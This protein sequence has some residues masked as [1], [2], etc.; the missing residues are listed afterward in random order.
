[1]IKFNDDTKKLL[2]ELSETKNLN[3]E[4]NILKII[5]S[6]GD[7]DFQTYI[8]KSIEKDKDTRRKRLDITKQIQ[9]QNTELLKWKEENERIYSELQEEVKKTQEAKLEAEKAKEIVENDLDILQKK[10]QFQ[11]MSKIIKVSLW[12]IASI[13]I[14]TTGMYVLAIITN[15]ETQI[16]G[17]TWSNLLGILLTN[18]FSI[19]GT[20]MGVKYASGDRENQ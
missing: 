2:I 18:S 6:D 16:I 3:L 1:M 11:L 5:D 20:I 7:V 13:G 8:I 17:S 9:K 12:L 19:V 15:T 14:L 10:S 4:G